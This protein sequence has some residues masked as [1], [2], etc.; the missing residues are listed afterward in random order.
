M[1]IKR[2]FT[3]I[4]FLLFS[5]LSFAQLSIQST[6]VLVPKKVYIGD[7]AELRCTFSSQLPLENLQS[8]IN[9]FTSELNFKEYEIN[10][11]KILPSGP[12]SYTFIITFI[13]WTTGVIKF[14]S[15]KISDNDMLLSFEGIS[16][17]SLVEGNNISIKGQTSPLLLPGTAYK[18]YAILIFTLLIIIVI[19]QLIIKHEAVA[20]YFSNRKLLRKYK[21]NKK[22]TIK[23]LQKL[24][25]KDKWTEVEFSEKIQQ[26]MRNYLEKRFDYPFTR[27]VSSKIMQ[28]YEKITCGLASEKKSGA[29]EIIS[30]IFTRT[31]FIRYG[32]QNLY[33]EKAVFSDGEKE[34][35]VETLKDNIEKLESIEKTDVSKKSD[36]TKKTE[37]VDA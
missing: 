30:G 25:K 34:K 3:V 12:S 28:V 1:T 37:V 7:T 32:Q 4:L 24:I 8:S 10:D 31:D 5:S 22:Q 13:P 29:I 21:K 36:N 9:N 19:V 17:S 35:I 2:F 26:I 15:Y 11:V 18:L 33:N 16:I 27:T 6:Q 23:Q 14:P 20:F